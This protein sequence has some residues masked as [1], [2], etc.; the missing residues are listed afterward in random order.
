LYYRNHAKAE[1][2]KVFPIGRGDGLLNASVRWHDEVLVAIRTD[3]IL[4]KVRTHPKPEG[5][6]NRGCDGQQPFSAGLS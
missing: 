1:V 5:Y 4:L 2:Q 6:D 3:R